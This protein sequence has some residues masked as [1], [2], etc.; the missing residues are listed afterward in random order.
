MGKYLIHHGA[1]FPNPLGTPILAAGTGEVI[2][3]GKD[4]ATLL[5]PQRNFYGQAV[6]IRL[7][8]TYN[9]RS[10]YVLYGHVQRWLVEVG[11]RVE[12]GQPVAEVGQ[13]GVALGPHLH[14]E[15]R[16]GRNAYTAT[17][18]PE[19][20]LEPMPGH[21]TLIGRY[22]APDGKAWQGAPI[23]IYRGQGENRRFW[24]QI[25][26]YLPEAGIQPDPLWG[27]NFLL[28]DVPA[29]TYTLEFALGGRT[30]RQTVTVTPGST[31]SLV[32]TLP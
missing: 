4:D 3:A 16:L 12:P 8:R 18:N 13:E 32:V 29:G 19:F 31:R 15:V 21:G 1:D 11:Q 28:T 7:D 25:Y 2:F 9:G 14:L 20:W 10:V 26:T 6:V 22:L 27:E 30:I 5:G 23:R 17:I 24:T